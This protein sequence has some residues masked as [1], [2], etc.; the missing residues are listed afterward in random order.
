MSRTLPDLVDQVWTAVRFLKG[1]V[2]GFGKAYFA[3]A[4]PR[5]GVRETRRIIG[6]HVLTGEECIEGRKS[7][8]GIAKCSHDVDLHREGTKQTRIPISNG[9]SYDVPYGCLVPRGLKNMLIA[10]RC[11]SSTR[12]G[13][14]SARAMGCAMA[15]GQAAGTA[16]ALCAAAGLDD[17]REIK[18][19]ALRQTL[20]R[21]GAILDGTY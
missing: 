11:L 10:G 16:A 13:N 20:K 9:G 5:I 7:E 6:E 18:I 8:M 1:N 14:G 21:Q 2:P 19:E 17:V 3:A 15:T 4:A 12:E